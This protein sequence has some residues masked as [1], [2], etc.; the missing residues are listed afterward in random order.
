MDITTTIMAD[1]INT[2]GTYI[3]MYNNE[4]IPTTHCNKTMNTNSSTSLPSTISMEEEE[5][6]PPISVVVKFVLFM[7]IVIAIIGN[8]WVIITLFRSRQFKGV[9]KFH[10]IVNLSIIQLCESIFVLMVS[11]AVAVTGYWDFGNAFCRVNAFFVEFF[12]V[13]D[14]IALLFLATDQFFSMQKPAF[15]IKCCTYSKCIFIFS[16]VSIHSFISAAAILSSVIEVDYCETRYGCSVTQEVP[17][18]YMA[19][20]GIFSYA[21]PLT[22]TICLYVV[23]IR[24]Q[25][26]VNGQSI[27]LDA[28]YQSELRNIDIFRDKKSVKNIGIILLLWFILRAPYHIVD[29]IYLSSSNSYTYISSLLTIIKL[30]Y[31]AVI[32]VSIPILWPEIRRQMKHVLFCRVNHIATV[33]ARHQEVIMHKRNDLPFDFKNVNTKP[34]D[35]STAY[36]VPVLFATSSGLQ[37]TVIGQNIKET[38]NGIST[39]KRN[40]SGIR[41]NGGT[42]FKHFGVVNVSEHELDSYSIDVSEDEGNGSFSSSQVGS[43]RSDVT[44]NDIGLSSSGNKPLPW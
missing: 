28:S 21:I 17:V 24:K 38:V 43:Q 5:D 15:Y 3:E 4:T 32:P 36:Q 34:E 12:S 9:I 30:S 14:V 26:K 44:R 18:S 33:H 16:Y 2:T 20:V 25:M 27:G 35:S 6:I 31:P 10:F 1:N 37:L 13:A 19:S 39:I 22:L 40:T 11:F 41:L 42:V 23:V 7:F 8:I 29:C